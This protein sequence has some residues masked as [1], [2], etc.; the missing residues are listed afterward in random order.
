MKP[1]WARLEFVAAIIAPPAGQPM[2]GGWRLAS[3][4]RSGPIDAC[5]AS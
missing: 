4:M 1:T 3:R 2:P 5:R